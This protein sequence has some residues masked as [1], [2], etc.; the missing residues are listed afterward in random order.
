MMRLTLSLILMRF[1][2]LYFYNVVIK[3][4]MLMEDDEMSL[5]FKKYRLLS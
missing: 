5:F 3:E 2:S 4:H 1:E